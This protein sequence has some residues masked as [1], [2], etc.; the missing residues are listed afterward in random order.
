MCIDFKDLNKVCPK[1]Y[2]PLPRIDQLVD[3]IVGHKVISL[4]DAYQGYHHI[5]L[6]RED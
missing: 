5:P 2:Y 1:D 6:A 4:M 3:S